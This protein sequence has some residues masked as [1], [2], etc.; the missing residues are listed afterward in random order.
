MPTA[1]STLELQKKLAEHI[2]SY[3]PELRSDFDVKG[4]R[5]TEDFRIAY[6]KWLVELCKLAGLP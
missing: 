2:I 4:A 1:K 5:Y 6:N 3:A